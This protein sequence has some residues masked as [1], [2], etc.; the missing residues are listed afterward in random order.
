MPLYE[1]GDNGL[2]RCE[3]ASFAE[4]GLYERADLQRLLRE[5]PAALGEDLLIIAEEFGQWEDSRRRIDLLALDRD[6]HL[7]VLEMGEQRTQGGDYPVRR[8]HRTSRL[9]L[10]RPAHADAGR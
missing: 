9:V 7:V 5:Q 3:V 8:A 6:A 4:L 10:R 2:H 1:V